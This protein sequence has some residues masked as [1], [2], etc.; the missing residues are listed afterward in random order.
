MKKMKKNYLFTLVLMLTTQIFWAQ[1]FI[2]SPVEGNSLTE[3]STCQGSGSGFQSFYL[4]VLNGDDAESSNALV[5]APSGFQV[6][7]QSTNDW[8]SSISIN[9]FFG[10]LNTTVKVRLSPTASAGIKSGNV[11]ITYLSFS[12]T[13]AVAGTV[14]ALPSNMLS[15][16]D[17]GTLTP[18]EIGDDIGANWYDCSTNQ[19][20]PIRGNSYTPSVS[21]SYK[22]VIFKGSCTSTSDCKQ[23]TLATAPSVVLNCPTNTTAAA[24]QTQAAVNTAFATWLATASGTGGTNG[25]LTNNNT[26]APAAIGGSSTVTFTYTSTTAPLTTTCQATFTVTATPTVVLTC[27]TNTTAAACQTQAAVNTAFATWLATASGTG[28]TNGLLTNNNTGAP[29]AIGGSSTVTF[30]Y[31]STTAPLTTTC[32]ATFT[33]AADTTAPSVRKGEISSSYPN[34]AAAEAAALSATTATDNCSGLLTET[35]AT[36][37]RCGSVVITVTTKDSRL[38][39]SVVTYNTNIIIPT[40]SI[41]TTSPTTFCAGGNVILTSSAASSYL[42][43]NGATTRSITANASGSFT[44]TVSDGIC[45]S[46]SSAVTR[47]VVNPLATTPII[48]AVGTSSFC[49]G[50]SV[51][52]TSTPS[53]TYR[54]STGATT[55]SIVATTSGLYTVAVNNGTCNSL[56]SVA[57]RV[58]VNAIPSTPTISTSGAT[59]FCAGKSVTLTS[60]SS[61]GNL[62]SN[63]ANTQSITVATAGTYTVT[64]SNLGCTSASSSEATVTV[65]PSPVRPTISTSGPT[66][67]CSG[68]SVTLTSSSQTAN[69]WSNGET[70]PS[71]TV[72]TAG[73]YTVSTSSEGCTSTSSLGK[74]VLVNTLPPTPTISVIGSPILTVGGSVILT[75]SYATSNT[76][77]TDAKTRSITVNTPGTYSVSFASATCTSV[78]SQS[79]TVTV[80]N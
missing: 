45:T 49:T 35:V 44:V 38:N 70:T 21:G 37:G 71:I 7:P 15:L 72:S 64:V 2:I 53:T 25:V 54:W 48:S 43:S 56:S 14:N 31:T 57:R 50:G 41:T 20:L 16:S 9:V 74:T 80:N 76:W 65:Y 39:T 73:T 6:A 33:V 3:F 51:T 40:P 36:E 58:T 75:S 32:Q 8:A 4:T 1:I 11:T 23:V 27:P 12:N 52:L 59:S 30:N 61:S 17:S 63:G 47:V 68:G 55:Q 26:G 69:L 77:S 46:V 67:F 13:I 78:P 66:T 79:I 19:I 28:G 60:S 10:N 62:W 34:V 5:T 18:V 22:A 42:W 24:S 29:A